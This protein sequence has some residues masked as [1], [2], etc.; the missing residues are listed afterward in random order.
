MS[1]FDLVVIG[2]GFTGVAAAVAGARQGLSVLLVEN[3]GCL[4]GAAANN[5]VYPFMPWWTTLERNGKKERVPLTKGIFE[6]ITKRYLELVPDGSPQSFNIEYMKIVLDRL[7]TENGVRMLFDT[8]LTSAEVDGGKIT[9]VTLSVKGQV[10]NVAA[11][12]YIDATGDAELSFMAG[13]PCRL[14][15]EPRN[16]LCQPMTLCFRVANVDISAFIEEKPRMQELYK[17]FQS[18]G[19]IKNPR[20][21]ILTF[22]GLCEG[23][24]HF[25]STRVVRLNPTDPF[26][27]SQAEMCAREQMLELFLFLKE[28]FSCFK[29]SELLTSAQRIGIRESRMIEGEYVLTE[30]DL[31][32]CTKFPDAV[33]AGN[34]DIDIHNP[35]GSGTS[36]YYFPGG[37]YYTIP[38]RSLVPRGVN[39]LLTAGRCISATHEAQA[40]VR[41]MP[42]CCSL[43]E[44]AGVG[45][46]VAMSEKVSVKNADTDKIR[47]LLK[48]SGA[49]ID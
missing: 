34:Y 6:E 39:N 40:S 8:T 22:L 26:E 44:A 11:K 33:A 41:I 5:L 25:N 3:A 29:D 21:N 10:L 15:R 36:H 14:G 28:N 45:A 20:E 46:A 30:E 35:E 19:K 7:V 23:V 43:G 24:V 9:Q 2:G 31:K 47:A 27:L 48:V 38:Y 13:C 1:S 32:A 17:E 49:V 12:Y 16:S 4:G 18:A 42:I 37:A